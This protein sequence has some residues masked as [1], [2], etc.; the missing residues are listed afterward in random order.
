M[1]NNVEIEIQTTTR[2]IWFLDK[3]FNWWNGF[4]V[5]KV[6]ART[7]PISFRVSSVWPVLGII[8]INKKMG[9]LMYM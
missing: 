1:Y 9:Y 6:I 7:S 4:P 2:V 3:I 5:A 8:L